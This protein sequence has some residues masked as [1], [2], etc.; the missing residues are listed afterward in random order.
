MPVLRIMCAATLMLVTAAQGQLA[1][2]VSPRRQR[3]EGAAI[4]PR[5]YVDRRQD[6]NPHPRS[7]MVPLA[8]R[9]RKSGPDGKLGIVMSSRRESH[10]LSQKRATWTLDVE[11]SQYLG[12]EQGGPE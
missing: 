5:R 12:G 11:G 3:T 10:A 6:V 2:A 8:Q 9:S 4:R 1:Q 7:V